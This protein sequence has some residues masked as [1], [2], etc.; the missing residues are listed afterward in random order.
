M[1]F[2]RGRYWPAA[3]VILVLLM[4]AGSAQATSPGVNGKIYFQARDSICSGYDVYS[5]QVPGSGG[6]PSRTG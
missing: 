2:A 4:G 3:V 5:A 1:R 6:Q